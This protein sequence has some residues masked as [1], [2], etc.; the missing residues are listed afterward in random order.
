MMDTLRFVILALIVASVRTEGISTKLNKKH[1]LGSEEF[2]YTESI[3]SITRHKTLALITGSDSRFQTRNVF[4]DPNKLWPQGKIPFVFD[5]NIPAFTK[6]ELLAAMQEIEMSTYSGH[7][8]CTMWVPRTTETDYVH[9]AW[10][11]ALYGSTGLGRVGGRQDVTINSFGGRGHDDQLEILLNVMGLLP[12]VMRSDRD[13]YL[14][15]HINNAL[16]TDP[17]R[18]LTGVGTSTFGQNFDYDSLVLGDPYMYAKD[19]ANPVVT[20]KQSGHVMGQR[21][22]LS[23]ADATLLQ[24]AYHCAVDASHV[25]NLLDSLPLECHFHTDVCTFTQDH[26][27]NFDWVVQSGPTPTYGTGPNADYS[28]GSGKFALAAAV[29]HHN[30]VAR[31]ISP[32]IPAGEYCLR[33]NVH[34]Y[35]SDIGSMKITLKDVDGS[36]ADILNQQGQ[37]G[38]NNWYHT[39]NT[40]N[41]KYAFNV[42]ISAT[43]GDGDRGDIAIDDIYLY[44][45]ECIEWD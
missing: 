16:A 5:D 33:V 6:I 29:N 40:I 38:E 20:A 23:T 13:N 39:Y 34:M 43:I 2:S 36:S 12:E 45:G 10:T 42:Q 32:Q 44:N 9:I 24:H 8:I 26:F 21:V 22:S 1:Q 27:D 15:I 25:I 30:Q 19:S 3:V 7:K 14:T 28:S 37:I 4:T 17:F 18:T 31:L 41:S 35:G 11:S